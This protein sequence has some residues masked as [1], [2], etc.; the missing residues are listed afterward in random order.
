MKSV[1]LS[2]EIVANM[3]LR[4]P[5]TV[6]R[7]A[8]KMRYVDRQAPELVRGGIVRT[9]PDATFDN[10]RGVGISCVS[11]S[12]DAFGGVLYGAAALR[13]DVSIH[14]NQVVETFQDSRIDINDINYLE[15]KQRLAWKEYQLAYQLLDDLFAEP[16]RPDIILLDMPLTLQRAEQIN[17]L[18]AEDVAKEWEETLSAVTRFWERNLSRVFPEDP[19]GPIVV[20]LTRRYFGAILN[21]VREK[22]SG[23]S[24]E[25]LSKEAVALVSQNWPRL[26]EVGIMR[27][28]KG[29]LKARRRTAAYYY[30]ALGGALQRSE[31]KI[32]ADYGC[33]GLHI[34][35][36]YNTPVW[37]VET[38]GGTGRAGW[39]SPAIDRLCSLLSYLTLYDNP[40]ALPLPLWYAKQLVRMPKS[41]LLNYHREAI[42]LLQ[43]E[44]VD[45]SWLAGLAEIESERA[46]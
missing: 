37:Q 36:G 18:E 26:C 27:A 3:T 11:S 25:V 35:V 33:I 20:S 46:E 38:L 15:T 7:I 40:Q 10:V 43:D 30:E 23:A 22:Q 19:D 42:R 9:I 44:S 1:E 5:G 13:H 12:L 24:P 6:G 34:R 8:N 4:L 17:R 14:G 28:L 29:M 41:I 16:D 39:D 21:A 32:V 2:K 45:A 31:P